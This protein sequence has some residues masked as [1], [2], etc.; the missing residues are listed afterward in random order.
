MVF[1]RLLML[2][3]QASLAN[4]DEPIEIPFGG[5]RSRLAWAHG[6]MH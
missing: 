1:V 3:T 2:G 5:G 6:T 4:P